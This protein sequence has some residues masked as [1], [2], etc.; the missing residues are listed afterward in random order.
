MEL[1][2]VAGALIAGVAG[3]YVGLGWLITRSRGA[4]P[5]CRAKALRDTGLTHVS[6]ATGGGWFNSYACEA[7][8]AEFRQWCKNGL[9]PLEAW[10]RG[11]REPPPVAIIHEDR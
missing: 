3:T 11:V 10:E 7:C 2:L 5:A 9:V 8:S 1:I 4:C 6:D